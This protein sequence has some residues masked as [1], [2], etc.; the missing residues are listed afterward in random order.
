MCLI[1][2]QKMLLIQQQRSVVD[3]YPPARR[4]VQLAIIG[5]F[6]PLNDQEAKEWEE[7]QQAVIRFEWKKARLFNF[8]YMARISSDWQWFSE[9]ANEYKE[10]TKHIDN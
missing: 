2:L 8:M 6:R 7:S 9:L 10:L 1:F 5:K 3:V 4:L